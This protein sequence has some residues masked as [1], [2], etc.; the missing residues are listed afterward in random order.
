V[1]ALSV[2]AG[3]VVYLDSA[4]LIYSVE[5]IAPYAALLHGL[6]RASQAGECRLV[7]SELTLLEVLV[8][9][10]RHHLASLVAAYEYAL[11]RRELTLLP[12]SRA[13]LRAAADLRAL[14][15]GLKTP[16]AIHAA[17]ALAANATHFV[18]N[19]RHLRAVPGLAVVYLDDLI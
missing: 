13:V 9:P 18:T 5:Q 2:A 6:L 16:D 1:G 19:D 15:L 10:Q 4:P 3:S 8:V 7:T 17:T 11:S 12:V 14:S